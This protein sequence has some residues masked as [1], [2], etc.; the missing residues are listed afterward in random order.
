MAVQICQ[1][2]QVLASAVLS[3]AGSD[4]PLFSI[5]TAVQCALF[6]LWLNGSSTLGVDE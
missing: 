6:V 4:C 3:S 2:A 5:L 1:H